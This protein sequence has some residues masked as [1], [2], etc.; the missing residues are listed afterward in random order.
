[1]QGS[2]LRKPKDGDFV[3]HV[4]ESTSAGISFQAPWS[5]IPAQVCRGSCGLVAMALNRLDPTLILKC[6][7]GPAF[8]ICEKG[9]VCIEPSCPPGTGL[10]RR[11]TMVHNADRVF[12]HLK[13]VQGLPV[14]L[15]LKAFYLTFQP[16]SMIIFLLYSVLATLVAL[17]F[18]EPTSHVSGSGH[19]CLLF[20]FPGT[21]Y[22]QVAACLLY[23]NV[24]FSGRSSSVS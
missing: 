10:G 8:V 6:S 12:P 1:M 19:L 14:L 5:C 11:D 24:P 16:S 7:L 4:S 2:V 13:I 21:L 3:D 18:L 17:F 20:P 9:G 15:S 22:P 23:S